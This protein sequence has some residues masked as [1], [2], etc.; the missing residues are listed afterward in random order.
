MSVS[1]EQL[2]SVARALLDALE[3]VER[4]EAALKLAKEHAER[5]GGETLPWLMAEAGLESVKLA[6][7]ETIKVRDEVYASIPVKNRPTAYAWLEEHG[8]GGLIKCEVTIGFA[9][10]ELDRA[11]GLEAELAAQGYEVSTKV[12]VN[13]QTLRAFLRERIAA[14]DEI[15]LDL[16]GAQP[17]WKTTI[18]LSK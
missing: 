7:G 9:R 1:M 5:L 8:F 3:S 18:K 16:F 17:V 13:A 14:G 4:A 10:E 12:D 15:P 6:G 11:K 2:G